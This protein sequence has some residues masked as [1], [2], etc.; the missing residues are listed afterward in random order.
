MCEVAVVAVTVLEDTIEVSL[1]EGH[2]GSPIRLR[3]LVVH[4]TAPGLVAQLEGWCAIRLPLL[5]SCDQSGHAQLAGP[6]T[7]LTG[8]QEASQPA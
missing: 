5:L 7:T 8:F 2:G 1:A 6:G 4:S 3:P